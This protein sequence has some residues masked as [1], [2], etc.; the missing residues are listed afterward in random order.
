MIALFLLLVCG[1]CRA[2]SSLRSSCKLS[3]K[4]TPMITMMAGFGAPKIKVSRIAT[5]ALDSQC[6]CGSGAAYE[7]C[8][9]QYHSSR[10]VPPNPVTAVRARFCALVHK[11]V[12]YIMATTHTG[13]KEYVSAEQTSKMK[14]WEKDLFTFA[15]EFDFLSIAFDDE[16]RDSTTSSDTATVSFTAKMQ[17]VGL[18]RS[19]EDMKEV[20]VFKKEE[21]KW[22]YFDATIKNP[23]KNINLDVVKPKQRAVKTLKKGVPSGNQG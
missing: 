17:R 5:P 23:F 16:A 12:P 4:A 22:Q 8:C 18:E 2:F 19:P 13:H 1:N 14:I 6:A 7:K 3:L 10:A 15:E 9:E 20:S 11:N 21:G